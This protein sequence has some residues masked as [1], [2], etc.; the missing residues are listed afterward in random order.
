MSG[1]H[2]NTEVEDTYGNTRSP[3]QE[4]SILPSDTLIQCIKETSAKIALVNQD[5]SQLFKAFSG[6]SARYFISDTTVND[7][8]AGTKMTYV[9]Y[10]AAQPKNGFDSVAVEINPP[11][12]GVQESRLLQKIKTSFGEGTS[13]LAFDKK[14]RVKENFVITTFNLSKDIAP[15]QNPVVMEV[16]SAGYKDAADPVRSIIIYCKRKI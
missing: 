8:V 12:E 10:F 5:P 14:L 11:I 9:H 2:N 4:K 3:V 7:P 15:T 1:K 13:R 16:H 6:R